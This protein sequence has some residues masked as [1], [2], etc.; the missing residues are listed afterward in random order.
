M[1]CMIKGK[2]ERLVQHKEF[3]QRRR[4]ECRSAKCVWFCSSCSSPLSTDKTSDCWESFVFQV[5]A[6][7]MRGVRPYSAYSRLKTECGLDVFSITAWPALQRLIWYR[8]WGRTGLT[9]L[10]DPGADVVPHNKTLIWSNS[11]YHRERTS[12]PHPSVIPA[13]HVIQ[14][15]S[16]TS[17]VFHHVFIAWDGLKSTSPMQTKQIMLHLEFSTQICTEGILPVRYI[18]LPY[19]FWFTEL[20]SCYLMIELDYSQCC[21]VWW[22]LSAWLDVLHSFIP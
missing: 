12:Q 14:P 17:C 22:R 20:Q 11:P 21:D 13:L 16:E 5:H 2:R 8:D 18:Q 9:Q 3:I 19:F 10:T 4:D 7:G 15:C 6:V 1:K